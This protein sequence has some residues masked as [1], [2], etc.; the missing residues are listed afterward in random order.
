MKAIFLSLLSF[1]LFANPILLEKLENRRE[2]VK[3]WAL[4]CSDGSYSEHV[5]DCH[6]HD[7]TLFAGLGCLGAVL[8]DDAETIK[9]R[10]DDVKNAQGTNGRWWRGVTRVD[11][12]KINSFS[13]DMARGVH[14]YLIAKGHLNKDLE[15]KE[16]VKKS[17]VNWFKWIQSEEADEK[18]CTEFTA[19][20]CR[21]TIGARNLFY[22]T[23]GA[24]DVMPQGG[25]L[26]RK[27]RKSGWYLKTLF[28]L[29]T[30]VTETGYP[31]HL[32]ASSLL[33]YRVLNM[34]EGKIK[35]K[36][37]E[38]KMRKVAKFLHKKDEDNALMNFFNNGV[39][40]EL[41]DQVLAQCP[42]NL[43]NPEL[44]R[45]DFQWQRTTSEGIIKITDGHD[46]VYLMNLM[47]AKLKGS[48]YW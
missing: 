22:N 45:R 19:N 24:L 36:K 2:Q 25:G 26:A 9:K 37:I 20:R 27:V 8:A 11:D 30:M 39:S 48:L 38:K 32:K 14:A 5:N 13:R 28:H 34:Q 17:A 46:C 33:M 1:G 41:V 42:V 21:I 10:C 18:L 31:R 12:G 23:F 4:E 43:P 6:Q 35:D 29:E 40:S 3:S 15:E 44:N 7:V 16:E 47:I